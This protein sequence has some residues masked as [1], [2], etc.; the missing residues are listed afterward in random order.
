MQATDPGSSTV[1]LDVS[2]LRIEAPAGRSWVEIVKGVSFTL[3]RGE[4]LGLIGE[5]GAGKSTIGLAAM[6]YARGGCRISGGR[7]VFRGEDLRTASRRRLK[8]IRGG[9]IA[10]V[11]Q[12]AA[13]AFNPAHRI[14]DQYI[15]AVRLHGKTGVKAAREEAIALYTRLRLPDPAHIGDRYPHELSGGQLQRAMVAMAMACKPDII[16]FDEPTTALYVITRFE[17][18]AAIKDVISSTGVAALYIS[19]DLPVVAQMADRIVVLRHGEI[20]EQ[21][22]AAALLASPRED[23]TRQLLAVRPAHKRSEAR[24]GVLLEVDR[25]SASYG[26]ALLVLDEISLCLDRGTTLAVVGESGS[27][28]STLGRVVG[29]LLAPRAGQVSFD[30]N[31]LPH[32]VSDRNQDL[33]WKIQMIH[34]MPDAALNPSQRVREAIGRVLALREG[35]SGAALEACIL[36][37]MHM[38][39]LNA[40]LIDRLPGELSGGQKQRVCIARAIAARPLLIV[41]DEVTS[42]LDPLVARGILDL[43]GRLQ[44]ETGVSYLFITHDMSIVEQIS[45]RVV[46][47]R[48]GRVVETGATSELMARPTDD[49]TV[50]LLKAVPRLDTSWLKAPDAMAGVQMDNRGK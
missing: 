12:S 48:N 43:L 36:E 8:G 6:A 22:P 34:Q 24:N 33:L 45:D 39:G 26:N 2:D 30:G 20:V 23:Y 9:A 38:V 25:L 29:G 13:A 21:G 42:A 10:Y 1:L 3:R 14:I 15:E 47:M 5:S 16:V 37:F 11:A 27:G 44:V 28:K 18:L 4:V 41:C 32:R 50:R 17:V 40:G 49:Y 19:H 31:A 46:V 35:L 7:I